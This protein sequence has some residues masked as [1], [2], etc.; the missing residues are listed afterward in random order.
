M[1]IPA[2]TGVSSVWI[3]QDS[4]DQIENDRSANT[5]ELASLFPFSNQYLRWC[6][7]MTQEREDFE[8]RLGLKRPL[9]KQKE[10]LGEGPSDRGPLDNEIID[11][12]IIDREYEERGIKRSQE[13][14]PPEPGEL[15]IEL[16]VVKQ[17]RQE[18]LKYL[19][20][21]TALVLD[22]WK[23]MEGSGKG[24]EDSLLSP[25]FGDKIERLKKDLSHIIQLELEELKKIKS[26]DDSEE[27]SAGHASREEKEVMLVFDEYEV[28]MEEAE[29]ILPDIF[30]EEN[31][32]FD[33]KVNSLGTRI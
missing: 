5:S 8:R 31:I 21:E 28:D 6:V 29:Q 16:G 23:S 12:E 2:V 30:V 15:S 24:M 33:L 3:A 20:D 22:A 25:V 7:L 1:K 11:R 17:E 32:H 9:E 18:R 19:E 27:T 13:V 10:T 4:G 26:K 14:K